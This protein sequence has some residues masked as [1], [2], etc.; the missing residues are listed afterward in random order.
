MGAVALISMHRGE[1]K[2]SRAGLWFFGF[3]MEFR[4]RSRFEEHGV[5][6]YIYIYISLGNNNKKISLI[7]GTGEGIE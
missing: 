1:L 7:E 6:I 4:P 3:V 5:A 2:F